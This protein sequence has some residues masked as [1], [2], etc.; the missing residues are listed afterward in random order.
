[1]QQ[2]QYQ[3]QTQMPQNTPQQIQNGGFISVRSEDEA[4]NYAVAHGNSVTFFNEN[5]TEV[6]VK[7]LGFGQFDTP[8]FDIYDLI[9]RTP[10]QPEPVIEEPKIEYATKDDLS[11]VIAD[12]KA[13]KKQIFKA[14]VTA[15][16]KKAITRKDDKDA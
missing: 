8:V 1:M 9:K 5:G 4:R 12:I 14:S 2:T 11:A 6:Y 10:K 15:N 16:E 3:M 7:T 13:L